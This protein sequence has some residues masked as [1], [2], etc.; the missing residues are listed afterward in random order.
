M[1]DRSLRTARSARAVQDDSSSLFKEKIVTRCLSGSLAL[2][3]AILV[4]CQGSST[5]PTTPSKDKPDPAPSASTT[6]SMIST[7]SPLA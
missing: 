5:A 7:T 3:F 6:G 1:I 2:S 4:G